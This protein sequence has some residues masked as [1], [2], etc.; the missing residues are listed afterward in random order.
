ME[1]KESENEDES[2]KPSQRHRMPRHVNGIP[3]LVEPAPPSSHEVAAHDG[4]SSAKKVDN[5]RSSKVKVVARTFF[6]STAGCKT[7]PSLSTPCPMRN[8]RID[9]ASND[10]AEQKEL[11][12]K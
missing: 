12:Q 7:Q 4:A 3:L 8:R 5:S 1:G 11:E 9:P 10:D 6:V 2:T